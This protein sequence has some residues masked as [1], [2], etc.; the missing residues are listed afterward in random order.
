MCLEDVLVRYNRLYFLDT[1]GDEWKRSVIRGIFIQVFFHNQGEWKGN[2][3][4]GWHNC[5]S[6]KN[7]PQYGFEIIEKTEV[8]INLSQKDIRMFGGDESANI[9]F[10]LLKNQD[11]ENALKSVIP[12]NTVASVD[13]VSNRDSKDTTLFN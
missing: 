8:Y 7:N 5:T 2:T 10:H 11:V 4:G 1:L 6:W 12:Q 9:G 3:A 13:Y